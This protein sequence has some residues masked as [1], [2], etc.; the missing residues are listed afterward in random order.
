MVADVETFEAQRQR[1]TRLAY[2]MLGSVAEA[3]DA[4]QDA[5]LRWTRTDE[6]VR[7]PAGWLVRVTSR[8]CID[9]LRSAKVQREAYRGPWLPEPLI[10]ELSVDPLE[11]AEDVSVAFLLALERLSPLERAVFLLHDVFD[12]DYASVAETLGR[13]E[14][15]VRQLAARARTHVKDSKPRFTVSQE[16][17]AKLAAAFMAAAAQGDMKALSA[18]LAE[19][20]VLI[21]DGGGKRAAAL[22]PMSGREDII[23]LLEGI[24]WRAG[25]SPLWPVSFRAVRINGYPGV[26]ME[27]EDGPM[28][29]AFQPGEDGKLAAIYLVRNP[30]KL[31]RLPAP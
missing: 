22:R 18:V 25:G 5:W 23:R 6:E 24:A 31:G 30:D 7:D 11:R 26:I 20:A 13:N 15:A 12:E 9:R 10:E 3:E 16:D 17:A 27:R 14:A 28:T 8:L 4:V 21:S 1:L 2:R 19:D 29:V